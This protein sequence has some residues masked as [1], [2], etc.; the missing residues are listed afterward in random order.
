MIQWKYM[1]HYRNHAL[2]LIF[3]IAGMLLM[4]FAQI[5]G[6]HCNTIGVSLPEIYKHTEWLGEH[7][8]QETNL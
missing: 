3:P 1:D 7:T 4:A 6:E 8:E 2:S 5:T